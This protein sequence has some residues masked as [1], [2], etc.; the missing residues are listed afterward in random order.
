[1]PDVI[2]NLVKKLDLSGGIWT[3]VRLKQLLI[4]REIYLKRFLGE[5]SMVVAPSLWVK[6]VLMGLGISAE[7]IKIVRQ[8]VSVRKQTGPSKSKKGNSQVRLIYMGRIHSTKGLDVVIKAITK[9]K[10]IDLIF[11]I[12]GDLTEC[13]PTYRSALAKLAGADE[14]IVFKGMVSRADLLSRLDSYDAL[15]VPSRCL[16]TGPLV[17]LEAFAAGIPVVGSNLGGISERITHNVDGILA[18]SANVDDWARAIHLLANSDKLR[19][20]LKEGIRTPK[21]STDVAHEMMSIY[22]QMMRPLPT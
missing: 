20:K 22:R 21:T 8:G 6:P 7:K 1:M 9:L 16:E 15:L 10:E 3:A 11:D 18:G 13:D 14:R 5:M 12:Y 2:P 4:Q 19:D 17:V